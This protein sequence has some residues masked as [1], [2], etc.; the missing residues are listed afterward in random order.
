LK[1]LTFFAIG[2]TE[3]QFVNIVK[4]LDPGR[5]DVH[6]A[7]F[8]RWGEFLEEVEA[9]G[10][11]LTDYSINK[12]AGYRTIKEQLR[13]ASYLRRHKIQVMHTYGFYPNVFGIP[14]A[15]MAGVPVTIAAIR[16]TGECLSPLRVRLQK[17]V[18][19]LADCIL[20]NA[21]AVRDW[22]VAQGYD[23]KKIQ[24][25]HNGIVVK[26]A[27]G[28]SRIREEFGLPE[29]AILV[30]NICRLQPLKGLNYFVEAAAQVAARYGRARFLV[31]G[32]GV[33]REPVSALSKE[34]GVAD[35]VI[36]TGFRTDTPEILSELSISV[37][38]SLTEGLS[39]TL[40]E[41]SAS[42]IPV[43]ATR[44][45]GSPEIVLDGETGLIVPPRDPAALADAMCL[46]LENP[47]FARAMGEAGRQR[48]HD[49]FSVERNVQQTETLYTQLLNE[50]V[51]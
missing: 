4:R 24:V 14:A 15:K 9:T 10:C 7:C 27:A 18:C 44:V 31:V 49:Y 6:L 51:T 2:G 48:V 28:P 36:F 16:D 26:K 50:A 11:P 41:S 45:G 3:R 12:L 22:L 1:F 47:E 37:S 23:A 46:L 30:G 32:D 17:M 43:I 19:G 21:A 42:G 35:K 34:L 33:E 20:V 8:K 40:L 38:S 25:I 29:D 13:F 5:F 39:N